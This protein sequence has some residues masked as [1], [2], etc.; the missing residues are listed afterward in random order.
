MYNSGARGYAIVHP[1]PSL[2]DPALEPRTSVD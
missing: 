2:H 1:R